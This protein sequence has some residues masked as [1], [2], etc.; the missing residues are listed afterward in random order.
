MDYL[1]GR[2]LAADAKFAEA[3][4]S[5]EKVIHSTTGGK[6]ETAAM[7]Q[8][9]IGET[10]MHQKEYAAALREYLKV[11]ILYAYPAWQAAALLQAAKCHEFLDQWA[12][13]DRL[14]SRLL[15]AY[16]TTEFKEEATRRLQHVRKQATSTTR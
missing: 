16:P 12:E 14:Y 4:G 1:I 3:R 15:E 7:A 9:M 5:Y 13:A 11:E 6:T 2:C 10:F 8:W